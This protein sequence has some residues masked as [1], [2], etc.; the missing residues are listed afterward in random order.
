M[1]YY[2]VALYGFT[3]KNV[4]SLSILLYLFDLVAGSYSSI[5]WGI[6]ISFNTRNG[7]F[8]SLLFV[9]IGWFLASEKY[10]FHPTKY[11]SLTFV[12]LG[13]HILE[14]FVLSKN[15]YLQRTVI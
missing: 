3:E 9:T 5:P 4:L 11:I 1:A 6:A 12:G 10:T 13:I 15:S 8:F 7:P 2:F 14:V